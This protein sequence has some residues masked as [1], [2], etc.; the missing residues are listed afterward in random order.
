MKIEET[1]RFSETLFKVIIVIKYTYIVNIHV[2]DFVHLI[3]PRD[4]A[5]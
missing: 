2:L 5:C 4:L 1:D 3:Q